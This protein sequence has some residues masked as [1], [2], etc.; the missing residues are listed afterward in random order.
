MYLEHDKDREVKN[1]EDFAL[2][3]L[4][5]SKIRKQALRISLEDVL[6]FA[7]MSGKLPVG[8]FRNL[9]VEKISEEIQ[10]LKDN[11]NSLGVTENSFLDIEFHDSNIEAIE[12]DNG[13]WALPPLLLNDVQGRQVKI[14]GKLSDVASK[15]L[16]ADI[17]DDKNDVLKVW[18]QYLAMNCLIEKHALPIEKNLIFSKDGAMKSPFFKDPVALLN[19]YVQYYLHS[20]KNVSPLIPEWI[21]DLMAGEAEKWQK[22]VQTQVTSRYSSFYQEYLLW[23]LRGSQMPDLNGIIQHWK[24]HADDLYGDLQNEWY[25]PKKK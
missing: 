19:R 3:P 11:L 23:I 4:E 13:S 25:P 15:G 22:K 10:S 20:L 5:R 21:P 2:S 14:I 9:A 17:K 6:R 24:P 7:E 1:E 18:P 12:K 8:P 16:V